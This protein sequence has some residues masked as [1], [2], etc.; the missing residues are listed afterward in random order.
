MTGRDGQ[1]HR[2]ADRQQQRGQPVGR[3]AALVRRQVGA[4][5]RHAEPRGDVDVQEK[6]Q[7]R[8]G[9]VEQRDQSRVVRSDQVRVQGDH[10]W[11]YEAPRRSDN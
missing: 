8:H 9:Q 11:C 1:V 10:T 5:P 3:R 6:R 7:H 4:R 2:R